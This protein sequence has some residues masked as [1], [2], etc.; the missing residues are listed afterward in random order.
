MEMNGQHGI[1]RKVL[2][3]VSDLTTLTLENTLLSL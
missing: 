2:M 1:K 3:H